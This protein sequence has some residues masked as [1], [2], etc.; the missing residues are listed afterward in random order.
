MN[1]LPVLAYLVTEDWY[2]ISHRLPMARAA[3]N[4]GYEVHVLTNVSEHGPA[5][6]REGFHLHPLPW[7]RGSL[8]PLDL[9]TIVFSIRSLY[10]QLRPDLVHHV[11]LQ[12]AIIGSL[13]AR[14]LP[15]T[16]LNALAGLG[17]A[18]S[19]NDLKARP[20]RFVLATLLRKL[21]NRKRAAVLVQNADDR[22]MVGSLGIASDR[23][24]LKSGIGRRCRS[25]GAAA[26]ARR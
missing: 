25:A 2:F 13:A 1:P 26:R 21:L 16:C 7:R 9:L 24:F 8:N 11:A 6:E 14:G 12:P 5:I 22:A 15:V 23:I 18:F 20:L 17:Y 19:S 4:A 3:R 10:K